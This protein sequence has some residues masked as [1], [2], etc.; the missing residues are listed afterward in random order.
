M[1]HFF[2]SFLAEATPSTT[3]PEGLFL[4]KN[5]IHADRAQTLANVFGCVNIKANALAV[6]PIKTY[7]RTKKGKV[8]V[9]NHKLYNL[10]RYSP[11]P[12]LTAS[13]WKK[14]MS[15]DLDLRGNHYCQIIRNGLGDV[16]ALYPLIS[17]LMIV[18]WD[19]KKRKKYTYAGIIVPANQILHIIDIP[20]KEGLLGLSRI[21][22][23]RQTLEFEDNSSKHGNKSFKNSVATSGAFMKDGVLE[24]E[25][26]NRLKQQLTEQYTGLNNTG[27]PLLLEDALTFTPLSI[28][29]S[30][31]Q[32]L[33]SRKF[34]R[35]QIATIFGVPVSMLN[36]P[37]NTA[38][39][40]LEQKKQGFHDNTILPLST[41]VEERFRLSLLTEEEKSELVIKFK[42]NSLM[43][44]DMK[45]RVEYYKAMSE[46]GALSPNEIRK[47]EDMN[48]YEGG[49]KHFI[50]L[51]YET[52]DNIVKGDNDE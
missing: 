33:E 22:K 47:L 36:D 19:N 34:N 44:A 29:N 35:E 49:D 51:S 14:M 8:E 41:L 45:T 15:Q 10:L 11:N 3:K 38:F 40:N 20:D 24:E 32:W 4:P 28:N 23:A 42:Y 9:H 50:Q 13:E 21:E 12:T 16:V 31:A 48:G 26:Y 25:A 1:K 17:D 27:K 46:K 6:I 52:V 30:D 39:G 18:E 2:N 5:T 37:E 7:R 43:R